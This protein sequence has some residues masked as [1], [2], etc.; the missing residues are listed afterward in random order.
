MPLS[1]RTASRPSMAVMFSLYRDPLKAL[2][3]IMAWVIDQR[4]HRVGHEVI[5]L[6]RDDRTGFERFPI[7]RCPLFPKS[8]E[9]KRT[10]ILQSNPH[11]LL[12]SLLDLPFIEPCGD[13]EAAAFFEGGPKGWFFCH[14]LCFGIDTLIPH[15][16]VFDPRRDQSPS[17]HH[18]TSVRVVRSGSIRMT[19][20]G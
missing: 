16:G 7:T 11:G 3:H 4:T 17:K 15:L 18:I 19:A 14:G 9:G 10:L 2:W 8:C 6:C 20:M 13:D 5:G 12:D 1:G